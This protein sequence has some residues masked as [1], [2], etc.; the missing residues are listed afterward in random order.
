M[1][2][3]L[4]YLHTQ[5]EEWKRDGIYQRLRVLESESAPE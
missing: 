3:P 2:N 4:E 5:L 1:G